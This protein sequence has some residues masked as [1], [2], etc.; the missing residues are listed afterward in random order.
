MTRP[1]R[2]ELEAWRSDPRIAERGFNH[3][4]DSRLDDG[5]GEDFFLAEVDRL[6]GAEDVVLDLG[7]GHGELTL[8]L[9]GRARAGDRCGPRPGLPGAGRGVDPGTGVT[10]VR[11]VEFTFA[12]DGARLPV[13]DA[14]VTVVVDRRGPTAD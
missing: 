10:N 2:W 8:A 13:A 7:C 11:F 6:V 12:G 3:A 1:Q 4:W 5:N 14:S 9:A